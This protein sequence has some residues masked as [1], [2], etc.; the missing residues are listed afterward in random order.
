MDEASDTAET[1]TGAGD[2]V[3]GAAVDGI[4]CDE[5]APLTCRAEGRAGDDLPLLLVFR[6]RSSPAPDRELL[7]DELTD[8]A[9]VF[10]SLA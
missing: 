1:E 9:D 5:D 7:A 4:G 2:W 3:R 8:A 10:R 6:R